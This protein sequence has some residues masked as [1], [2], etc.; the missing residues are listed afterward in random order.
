M[1]Y[2]GYDHKSMKMNDWIRMSCKSPK[3]GLLVTDLDFI[4]Y[5]YKKNLMMLVETK[6]FNAVMKDW[7]RNLFKKLD[8]ALKTTEEY[9]GFF[10]ISM[11]NDSPETSDKITINEVEVTKEQLCDFLSFDLKF[12][13]LVKGNL[14]NV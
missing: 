4:F 3:D 9:Q 13:D 6:T 11:S 14:N 12:K 1:T 10:L 5:D 2:Y 7:Q 8:S